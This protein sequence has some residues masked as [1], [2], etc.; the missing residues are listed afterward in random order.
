MANLLQWHVMSETT[1]R[2]LILAI[3]FLLLACCT[4]LVLKML[5][6]LTLWVSLV[7]ITSISLAWVV[8]S[9]QMPRLITVKPAAESR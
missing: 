6:E 9:W 4:T 5:P 8:L 2:R 7:L 1:A 3:S